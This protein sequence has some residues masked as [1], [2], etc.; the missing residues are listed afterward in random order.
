MTEIEQALLE[1]YQRFPKNQS[2]HLYAPDVYFKDPMNEFRGIDRYK[3]MIQFI[4]TWFRQPHMEV[5]GIQR[6]GDRIRTDWTLSWTTPLPWQPRIH[7]PGWSELR[8]NQEGLIISHIDY[9]HCSRLDVV[10][11]HVK[12]GN[13]A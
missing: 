12:L 2:Y 9:W 6:E 13:S 7:I 11:Q 8:L 5:H 1:D 4:D 10:Q 3:K